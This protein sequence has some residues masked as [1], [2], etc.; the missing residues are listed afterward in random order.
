MGVYGRLCG[1][2]LA[3]TRTA[4]VEI[5]PSLPGCPGVMASPSASWSRSELAGTSKPIGLGSV[6]G[7]HEVVDIA[8]PVKLSL[9]GA[10]VR[11]GQTCL[12]IAS[13]QPGTR[14]GEA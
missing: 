3:P 4:T 12:L 13:S 10:E 5:A 11:H 14:D 8:K 6:V 7:K 1:I 2:L 9:R